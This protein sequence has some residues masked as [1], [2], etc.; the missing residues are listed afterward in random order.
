MIVVANRGSMTKHAKH[1]RKHD[2]SRNLSR[3]KNPVSKSEWQTALKSSRRLAQSKK[4]SYWKSE[5][6]SAGN[7]ARHVWRTVVNLLGESKSGAKPTFSLENYHFYIEKKDGRAVTSSAPSLQNTRGNVP[8]MDSFKTM[9]TE[10]VITVVR[11]SP[12]K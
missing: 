9:S 11:A 10:D 2:G 7:N 5:I 6:H 8:G 1:A 3:L 12:S 4:A